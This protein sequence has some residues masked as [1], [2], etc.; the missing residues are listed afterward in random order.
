[1]VEKLH[2]SHFHTLHRY[3]LKVLGDHHEAEDA[4]HEALLE[5]VRALPRYDPCRGPLARW[6]LGIARLVALRRI[7][8]LA[9]VEVREPAWICG[10]IEAEQRLGAELA[11][12]ELPDSAL[13]AAIARLRLAQRRVITLRAIGLSTEE[14]ASV[15]GRTPA[16]VYK[17]EQRGRQL[18]ETRVP[19]ISPSASRVERHPMAR[20]FRGPASSEARRLALVGSF[21]PAR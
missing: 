8:K 9:R 12:K 7:R 3:L 6:L 14:I 19:A 5:A 21:R 2:R 17:T 1:M 13:E 4:A 18:V 20:L 16:W 10:Q 15:L 11:P